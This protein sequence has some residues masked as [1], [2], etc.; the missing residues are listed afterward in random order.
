MENLIASIGA[1]NMDFSGGIYNSADISCSMG[2]VS[3]ELEGSQADFNYQLN[4]VAG[5]MEID[6]N[7]YSGAAVDRT[8]DNGAA[9]FMEI[10]CSMGN[11]EV[12]FK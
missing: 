6:G 7:S 10:D 4:C 3:M 11:V 5:N 2:N 8:V 9:K 1:G 12:T